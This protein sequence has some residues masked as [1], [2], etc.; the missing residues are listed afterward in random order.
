MAL[1]VVLISG[2]F[3]DA[4]GESQHFSDRCPRLSGRYKNCHAV[5][6]NERG[7]LLYQYS[8]FRV[9]EETKGKV[10]IYHFKS[11]RLLDDPGIDYVIRA[12]GQEHMTMRSRRLGFQDSYQAFCDPEGALQIHFMK[13]QFL[14]GPAS[15]YHDPNQDNLATYKKRRDG[16]LEFQFIGG[17]SPNAGGFIPPPFVCAFE[18]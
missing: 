12:D 16:D 15:L 9:G 10:K 13:Q 8:T 14:G 7:A 5:D 11:S 1:G 3:C 18:K 17:C 2:G 4:H 6:P